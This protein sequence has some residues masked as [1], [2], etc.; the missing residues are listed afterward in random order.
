MKMQGFRN[1]AIDLVQQREQQIV[2]DLM[3]TQYT[4]NSPPP[5]PSTSGKLY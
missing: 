5:S 1:Y 3:P 4:K 2:V